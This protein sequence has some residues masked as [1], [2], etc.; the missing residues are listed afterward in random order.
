MNNYDQATYQLLIPKPVQL[1][2]EAQLISN[3]PT[4]SEQTLLYIAQHF[5]SF[6]VPE[7]RRRVLE[8]VSIQ[9]GARFLE[10]DH[11][12]TQQLLQILQKNKV[13]I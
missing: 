12:I 6:G 1:F 7:R 11:K 2:L 9:L 5:E 4:S 3:I 13:S 8:E 10:I